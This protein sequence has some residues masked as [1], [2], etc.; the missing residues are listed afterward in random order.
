MGNRGGGEQKFAV[1]LERTSPNLGN[2]AE[3]DL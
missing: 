3:I 1:N 2:F